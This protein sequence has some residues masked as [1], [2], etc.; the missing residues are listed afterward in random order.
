[1]LLLN[2][3]N[4]NKNFSKVYQLNF[5]LS[6]DSLIRQSHDIIDVCVE[7]EV[8]TSNLSKVI[9][10]TE[11]EQG[12]QKIKWLG[13]N[14]EELK[15][16]GSPKCFLINSYSIPFEEDSLSNLTVKGYLWNP[17]K[18]TFQVKNYE[19]GIRKGNKN[20]FADFEKLRN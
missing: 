12:D 9:L 18:T 5:E 7:L 19:Y 14:T 4:K 3:H 11:V 15:P 16:D 1:M 8:D 17:G 10:V 2:G 6:F 13:A 20:R